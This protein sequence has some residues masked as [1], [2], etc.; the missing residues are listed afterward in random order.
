MAYNAQ[1]RRTVR[2]SFTRDKLT[3]HECSKRHKIP[4]ATILSWKRN[5][6]AAGNDWDELRDAHSVQDNSL[7]DL[8]PALVHDFTQ[9]YRTTLTDIN[10]EKLP[11]VD[12]VRILASL[13]DAFAKF[14][15]SATRGSPELH[16]LSVKLETISELV[17]FVRQRYPEHATAMLEVLEPFGDEIQRRH[18]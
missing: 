12:K 2:D 9:L 7:N 16:K 17:T 5:D 11:A 18:G 8:A 15:R 13:S 1:V 4:Y 3:L 6:T 10:Q 14:V